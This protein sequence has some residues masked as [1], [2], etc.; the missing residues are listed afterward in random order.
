LTQYVHL[1]ENAKGNH[2]IVITGGIYAENGKLSKVIIN[3]SNFDEP[4]EMTVGE[5]VKAMLLKN[6]NIS[7]QPINENCNN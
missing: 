5:L 6:I 3:D 2:A 4:Y 7:K 1:P